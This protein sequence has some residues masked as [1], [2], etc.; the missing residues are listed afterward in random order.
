V[1]RAAIGAVAVVAVGGASAWALLPGDGGAP[2]SASASVPLG[3]AAVERRDLVDRQDVG[4]TLGY[5]GGRTVAAPAAGTIT[6]LRGEGA[7]VRRGRSLLSID[8]QATG[9]VLYGTRPMYRDL[10]P[11]VSNGRDVRQLERNLAGL[12]YDTGTVDTAWTSETTAAVADFQ[13][14]R[15][16]EETGMLR[17]T[18]VIVSDG[19]VRV[20]AHKAELGDAARAG[21]GVTEITTTTQEVTASVDAGLAASV[22]RGDAVTVTLPD[23]RE[24]RGAVTRV[25]TVARA[26]GQ[27]EEPTVE[28][29][30]RLR[31]RG[32]GR[33]DGAPVT[34]SIATD[35]TKGVLAVP[36]T[37][38]VATGPSQYAVQLAGSRALVPV[39]LGTSADGWAE[40]SGDGLG[41]G[42][43]VVV[44]Q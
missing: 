39:G 8:A 38:L 12:G 36:V 16:L 19:P 22:E 27:D 13:E 28:L 43:R 42:T 18:D 1:R 11:G 15:G 7:V 33:L 41:P 20:G 24:A 26:D 5:A 29:E 4:G 3:T 40:V 37:A 25:G 44:P 2:T 35:A 23:G 6:R 32:A 14:D 31:G 30:A 17:R 34:L 9:W 21:G 10:G